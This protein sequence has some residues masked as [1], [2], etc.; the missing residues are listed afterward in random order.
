MNSLPVEAL[1]SALAAEHAA[2]W[3]YGLVGAFLADRLAGQLAE[4]TVAHRAHRD[5]TERILLDA[6][7]Q[8][9]PAEPG[10]LVPQ[11]V[12]DDASALRLAVTAETDAAAAW[13]S[14]IEHSATEHDPAEPDVRN[15]AL[16]ALTG[17]AVRAARWRAAAGIAPPTVPFPGAP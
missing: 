6:G 1:Q 5:T 4:V 14:V 10:Y 17:A 3:A 11:P 13:R 12:T 7:H 8:P 15:L 16:E 9:V 2:V